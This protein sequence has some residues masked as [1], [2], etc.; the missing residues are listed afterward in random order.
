[1]VS[2][3]DEET[4]YGTISVDLDTMDGLP[5]L[6]PADLLR[7][8]LE[9]VFPPLPAFLES[10]PLPIRYEV[11]RVCMAAKVSLTDMR[12]LPILDWSELHDYD[13][14][15]SYMKR[16]EQLKEKIFP[17]KSDL[18]AWN[19]ALKA[20]ADICSI[21]CRANDNGI[22]HEYCH[23]RYSY[24]NDLTKTCRITCRDYS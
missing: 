13:R 19:A 18:A 14:L 2:D 4:D 22:L 24:S 7:K 5:E 20:E 6:T 11:T 17:R 9:N 12:F 21:F 23:F 10:A 15:W 3:D 16:H 1:M 8:T